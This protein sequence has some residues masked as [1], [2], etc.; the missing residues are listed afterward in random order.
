MG[1]VLTNL[2]M[3]PWQLSWALMEA[4]SNLWL[5][6]RCGGGRVC[7]EDPHVDNTG[8]SSA[9]SDWLGSLLNVMYPQKVS[10]RPTSFGGRLVNCLS[11][12]QRAERW[13]AGGSA[14]QFD[15][16]SA[17]YRTPHPTCDL[18][19]QAVST[20]LTQRARPESGHVNSLNLSQLILTTW[21]R[22][23]H[24]TPVLLPGKSHGRRA[25]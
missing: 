9:R 15:E 12:C 19:H 16:R 23:R 17:S 7:C 13:L 24:P 18:G 2:G 11:Y 3:L 25:W 22:Q 6:S 21:R 4:H 10:L 5:D 8:C 20:G 14:A 1:H